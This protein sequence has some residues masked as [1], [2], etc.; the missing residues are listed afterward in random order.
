MRRGDA[1][2]AL[3]V[4]LGSP[5]G[6]PRRARPRVASPS[7][8]CRKPYG[9]ARC[10]TS[11]ARSNYNV[12]PRSSKA[13]GSDPTRPCTG[14]CA[15][16]G[17]RR[18]SALPRTARMVIFA[19]EDVGGRP[20][21]AATGWRSPFRLPRIFDDLGGRILP[22]QGATYL[23]T[24]P[25]NASY[26]ALN[27]VIA[28]VRAS[29]CSRCRCTCATPDRADALARLRAQQYPPRHPDTTS[30]TTARRHARTCRSADRRR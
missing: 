25:S 1:R 27:A 7:R 17:S 8:T 11:G 5:N 10:A 4:H 18:G 19:T 14:S 3:G 23:A 2:I 29:N 26:A 16:A 30:G 15:H 6:E 20:A 21:R 22:A 12:I 9:A 13:C 24:A 28:E